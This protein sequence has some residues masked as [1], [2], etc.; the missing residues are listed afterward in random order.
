[1]IA[2]VDTVREIWERSYLGKQASCWYTFVLITVL[3]VNIRFSKG[4]D[5]GDYLIPGAPFTNMV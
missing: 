3:N 5:N 4:I 1:M 2:F